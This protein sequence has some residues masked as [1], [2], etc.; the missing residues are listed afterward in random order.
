[1]EQRKAQHLYLRTGFGESL[2]KVRSALSLN[3]TEVLNEIIDA[4]K[5]CSNLLIVP[6]DYY[7]KANKKNAS[8][9]ER[10]AIGKIQ[11]EY[12]LN[13]NLSWISKMCTSEETLREKMTLLWHGHFACMDDNPMH[14]QNLNNTIRQ[15]ALGK[16]S[17]L[18]VAVSKE[19]AMIQYLNTRENRKASPNENFA[20]E[21]MELFTLGRGNYTEADVREAARAFTG[22]NYDE[23][24][25]FKF[26]EK[27]HDTGIKEVFGK[28]GNF[29]GEDILSLILERRECAAFI[30]GKFYT[31]FVNDTPNK[32]M[33]AKISKDFYE[34]GYDILHVLKKLF[35]SEVFYNEA[36]LGVKIKSPIELIVS[37]ARMLQLEYTNPFPLIYV[38]TAMGQHL[39]NP[40]DVAGWKGGQNWIDS[41][42]LLY[43]LNLADKIM[44]ATDVKITAKPDN[45]SIDKRDVEDLQKMN[46]LSVS[47]D[48][49]NMMDLLAGKQNEEIKKELCSFLFQIKDFSEISSSIDTLGEKSFTQK[50]FKELCV[51]L[52][53][54][55]EYQML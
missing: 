39:F 32:E 40:P 41:T 11:N 25:K 52:M 43:R 23:T 49:N 50:E 20:R 38:Q 27:D 8:V 29:T 17:D 19:A 54:F 26:H 12:N 55:P 24:G 42:T 13:L 2:E 37:T 18:L 45:D 10:K 34:S 21:V 15:C 9:E 36:N 16:F 4:S 48:R 1:M 33:I 3:R 14:A 35:N 44:K 7:L 28:R 6:S 47:F 53:S 51:R 46:N 30:A 5:T 31:W 22:W